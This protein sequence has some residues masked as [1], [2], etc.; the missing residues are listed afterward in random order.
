MMPN[1]PIETLRTSA[2]PNALKVAAQTLAASERP[3]DHAALKPFLADAKFLERLNTVREYQINRPKR[4]RLWAVLDVLRR[5]KAP[6]AQRVLV[7]LTAEAPYNED[8]TP[9]RSDLL[10]QACARIRPAPAQ[11]V[12][13]WDKH[14]R[15]DDGHAPLTVETL[16]ENSSAPALALLETKMA[17]SG[18][19]AGERISW[20]HE[21]ILPRRNDLP[22]LQSC[23]RMLGGSLPQSLRP[24]LAETLFDYR[25]AEWFTPSKPV[26]CP[27]RQFMSGEARAELRAIGEMAL[28]QIALTPEQQA[29]V[30]RVLAEIGGKEK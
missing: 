5:N 16:L 11:V 23:R 18:H 29:V 30:K 12:A 1:T 7:D 25:P 14:C 22:V 24:A 3:E 4:L 27:P 21:S 13:Y 6:S 2:E 10:I 26:R 9:A 20:M 8:E 17:D 19:E 15:P 28:K